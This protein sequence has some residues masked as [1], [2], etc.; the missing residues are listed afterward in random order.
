MKRYWLG[1]Y[2]FVCLILRAIKFWNGFWRRWLFMGNQIFVFGFMKTERP[3]WHL[4]KTISKYWKSAFAWLQSGIVSIK[5]RQ[6]S[7][8]VFATNIYRYNHI[9][10]LKILYEIDKI[11]RLN[12]NIIIVKMVLIHSKY[13]LIWNSDNATYR[14]HMAD[15]YLQLHIIGLYICVGEIKRD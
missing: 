8:N 14:F 2:N 12:N 11:T 3:V 15:F 7:H 5:T 9:S 13:N 4:R 10:F 1:I 6:F